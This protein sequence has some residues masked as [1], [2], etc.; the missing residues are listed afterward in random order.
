[1]LFQYLGAYQVAEYVNSYEY[2]ETLLEI[3]RP[4][5]LLRW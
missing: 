5:S 1:M 4:Q 3:G 2:E